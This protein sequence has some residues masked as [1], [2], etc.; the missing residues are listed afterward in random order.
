MDNYG[1]LVGLVAGRVW[2]WGW[3]RHSPDSS[4]AGRSSDRVD[5]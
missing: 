4:L 1:D 2:L 5:I 3:G